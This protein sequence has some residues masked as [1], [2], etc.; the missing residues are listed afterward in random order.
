LVL[1]QLSLGER[2]VRKEKYI[3]EVIPQSVDDSLFELTH[4]EIADELNIKREGI[5]H[6]EKRAMKKVKAILKEK[7]LTFEDLVVKK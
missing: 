2:R 7:G 5:S 6:I 3:N 4:Q 1:S